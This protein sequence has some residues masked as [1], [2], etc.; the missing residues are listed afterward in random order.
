MNE[1][2]P[3]GG[4]K[5]QFF[6]NIACFNKSKPEE[7][8]R[9]LVLHY[10]QNVI[11][12]I[13]TQWGTKLVCESNVKSPNGITFSMRSVWMLEEKLGLCNFITAYPI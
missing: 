1:K 3:T 2:H 9:V 11:S 7:L 6:I 8:E 10:S 4:P 13:T 12:K 5:A